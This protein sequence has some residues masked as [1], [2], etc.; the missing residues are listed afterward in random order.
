VATCDDP[1]AAKRTKERG[2]LRHA[3]RGAGEGLID[4]VQ[5]DS[6]E[7]QPLR[8]TLSLVRIDDESELADDGLSESEVTLHSMLRIPDEEEVVEIANV[9]DARTGESEVDDRQ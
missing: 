1:F 9:T 6:E 4:G 2:E 7:R 3:C 5:L 8:G